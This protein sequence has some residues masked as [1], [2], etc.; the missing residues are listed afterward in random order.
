MERIGPAPATVTSDLEATEEGRAAGTRCRGPGLVCL[1]PDPEAAARDVLTRL[2][3][4]GRGGALPSDQC[5][6][7]GR[8]PMTLRMSPS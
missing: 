5:R 1:E 2:D 3:T 4:A 6:L 8:S 7:E